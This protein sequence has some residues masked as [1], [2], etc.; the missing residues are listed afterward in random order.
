MARPDRADRHSSVYLNININSGHE[1]PVTCMCYIRN[2]PRYLATGSED[3]TVQVWDCGEIK[4]S[5]F[6]CNIRGHAGYISAVYGANIAGK[7]VLITA[8]EDQ[9]C[10]VWNVSDIMGQGEA[11]AKRPQTKQS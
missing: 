7:I 4:T 10:R 1:K 8:S 11:Q 5:R 6:V 2:E 9:T 3:K